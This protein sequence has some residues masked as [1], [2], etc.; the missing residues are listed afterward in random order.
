MSRPFDFYERGEPPFFSIFRSLLYPSFHL[1]RMWLFSMLWCRLTITHFPISLPSFIFVLSLYFY[2]TSPD[3]FLF[4]SFLMFDLGL[5][6]THHT[7]SFD[8]TI[9]LSSLLMWGPL[10]P[11]FMTFSTHCISCMRGMG[12]I[13]LG[14]LS[15]VSFHFLSFPSPYYLSLRYVPCLKTTLRP[16]LHTLCLTAHTWVILK[17]V[18]DYCL[19]HDGWG[20]MIWSTL[21][22]NHFRTF[23]LEI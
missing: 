10:G 16:W 17:M 13:S 23:L 5:V 4:S 6:H 7:C 9:H 1:F 12:I 8:V 18:G 20:P 2:H 14:S 22:H 3:F 21:G 15:L 19:E 11:G